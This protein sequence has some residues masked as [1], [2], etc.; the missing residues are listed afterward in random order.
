MKQ[1]TVLVWEDPEDPGK[2]LAEFPSV[3]GAHSWGLSPEEAIR[4][5]TEALM[6]VLEI[7][8]EDG[9]PFPDD[10]QTHKVVVNAA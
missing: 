6:L 8:K 9:K 2:W 4:N 10:I 7:L 5:A 3:H 1:Y